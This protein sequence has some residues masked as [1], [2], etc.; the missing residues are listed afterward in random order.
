[1]TQDQKELLLKDLCARLPYGVKVQVDLQSN[2]YSPIVCK[3][4]SIECAEIG[5]A[6]IGVETSPDTY[7]EFREFLCK[8]YLFPLS[9][10]TEEQELDYHTTCVAT[11]TEWGY[12]IH[13][14]CADSIDW[15]NKNHFDYRGLIPK[16]LAIDATGLNIYY[17]IWKKK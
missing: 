17:T 9:R 5:S 8:P 13:Y 3:V 15:L 2:T 11:T 6:F 7:N 16:S 1:M 10:M 14:D 4:C 12:D